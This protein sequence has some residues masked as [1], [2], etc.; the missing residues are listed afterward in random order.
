M[1]I[2]RTTA[3]SAAIETRQSTR[4]LP[5]PC[6]ETLTMSGLHRVVPTWNGPTPT[7]YLPPPLSSRPLSIIHT[8]HG[9]AAPGHRT[10]AQTTCHSAPFGESLPPVCAVM[11]SGPHQPLDMF[12][13]VTV[14]QID[15]PCIFRRRFPLSS[16]V[17][18]PD[19]AWIKMVFRFRLSARER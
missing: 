11:A 18:E 7:R 1:A 8:R 13:F 15:Q 16:P 14:A 3:L 17:H 19:Q 10:G 4:P 12:Q 6:L 2:E 5:G 9:L